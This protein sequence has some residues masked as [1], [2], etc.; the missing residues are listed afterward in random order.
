MQKLINNQIISYFK[1][2]GDS[3]PTLVFLHGW[4][5]EGRV[6]TQIIN[7]IPKKTIYALDLP[8][9]SVSQSF[10]DGATLGDYANL[11]NEFIKSENINEAIL[12]G[13]SFGGRIAIKLASKNA[14]WIKKIVLVDSAG[15]Q[16]KN[17]KKFIYK[18]I[19]KIVKPFFYIPGLDSLRQTIYKKIGP[20]YLATPAMQ[21]TFLNIINEDL[22]PLLKNINQETLIVWG[23]D[24]D[25]TP[26]SMAKTLKQNI[27]NAKLEIIENAGHFCFI[28]QPQ[29]FITILNNFI[30]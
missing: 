25:I 27:N 15:L 16:E 22:E 7:N 23:Q 19:A 17:L 3:S 21:K 29:K 4:R 9:F 18:I 14:S 20:D 8:G 26:I 2:A 1:K 24:D 10:K 11:V 6:F 30:N 13:H 5:S 28:D 12:I